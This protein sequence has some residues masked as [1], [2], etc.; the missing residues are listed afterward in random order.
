MID[1]NSDVPRQGSLD[2][3][4]YHFDAQF[5]AAAKL[6]FVAAGAMAAAWDDSF[7]NPTIF[8]TAAG[9]NRISSSRI[10]YITIM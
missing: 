9:N 6:V 7:W 1:R 3:S 4:D 10:R 2:Y 5:V 8:V